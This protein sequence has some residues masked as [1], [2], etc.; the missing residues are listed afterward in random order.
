[1]NNLHTPFLECCPA[2]QRVEEGGIEH[3]EQRALVVWDDSGVGL[4]RN[5]KL[6]RQREWTE[7]Q[8]GTEAEME[9]PPSE[10]QTRR[11]I[12][13]DAR[14]LLKWYASTIVVVDQGPQD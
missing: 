8:K 4:N 14:I 10:K 2:F 12:N 1:M 6:L 13:V 5:F 7:L 11:N 9:F 3:A